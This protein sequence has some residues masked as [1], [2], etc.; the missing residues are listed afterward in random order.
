M[1]APTVLDTL[2]VQAQQEVDR[3]VI[4][5]A[6]ALRRHN[7]WHDRR[8]Q[9]YQAQAQARVQLQVDLLRGVP[10]SLL[11]NQRLYEQGLQDQDAQD[12]TEETTALA[13]VQAAQARHR[14]TLVV[15]NSYQVLA[16][17]Q[18]QVRQRQANRA[19]QRLMDDLGQR[20]RRSAW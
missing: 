17:R 18:A 12:A 20:P 10:A 11:H 15:L 8:A 7:H 3:S 9:T 14:Q 1:L 5:L 13:A 2:I 19:E 16:Q 4:E 6:E